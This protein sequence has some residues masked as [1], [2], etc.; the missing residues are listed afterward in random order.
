MTPV[1]ILGVIAAIT[2]LALVLWALTDSAAI[3]SRYA[4]RR[5]QLAG[6]VNTNRCRTDLHYLDGAISEY[7]RKRGAQ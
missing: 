2:L 6:R 5:D 4:G 3:H 7:L 1:L